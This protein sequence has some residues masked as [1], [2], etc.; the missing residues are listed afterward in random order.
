MGVLIGSI[1]IVLVIAFVLV[2]AT[3]AEKAQVEK[4]PPDER[5]RYL[6]RG[7]HG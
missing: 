3:R 5:E 4:L 6:A 7:V 1:A 2:R